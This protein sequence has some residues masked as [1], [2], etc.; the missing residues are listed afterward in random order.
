MRRST[1]A[2]VSRSLPF[3]V[4]V[5]RPPRGVPRDQFGRRD[6]YDVWLPELSPTAELLSWA[7]AEPWTDVRWRRF[8]REYRRQMSAPG[9]R[10]LLAT[11][12]ASLTKIASDIRLLGSGPR[13][14]LRRFGGNP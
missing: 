8:A 12:A 10:H 4:P 14:G 9:P 1:N 11:I 13:A 5:R 7:L 3:Q 6:Y 2:E